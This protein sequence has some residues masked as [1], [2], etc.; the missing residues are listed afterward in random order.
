VA[1]SCVRANEPLSTIQD[2]KFLEK[3][4]EYQLIKTILLPGWI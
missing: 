4:T 2:E 3:L 1:S